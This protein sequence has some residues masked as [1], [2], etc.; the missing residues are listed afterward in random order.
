MTVNEGIEKLKILS[1]AG[2]GLFELVGS[3]DVFG[4]VADFEIG[5]YIQE[6]G[7]F[8]ESDQPNAILVNVP[9]SWERQTV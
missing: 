5:E 1:Q 4:S 9:Q 6:D 3:S 7:E 8:F 2:Y